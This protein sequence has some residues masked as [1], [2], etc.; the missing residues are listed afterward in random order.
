MPHRLATVCS[1]IDR[2]GCA[3]N[4]PVYKPVGR[5]PFDDNAQLRLDKNAGRS[6]L[7][8]AVVHLLQWPKI[9]AEEGKFVTRP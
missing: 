2:P 8:S 6:K 1:E 5:T 9:R 3:I 7:Q 4:A